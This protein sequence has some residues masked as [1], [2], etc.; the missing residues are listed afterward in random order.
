MAQK[1]NHIN[2]VD[3]G[4]LKNHII[5]FLGDRMGRLQAAWLVGTVMC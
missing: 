3:L 4:C 1:N 5:N 2:R